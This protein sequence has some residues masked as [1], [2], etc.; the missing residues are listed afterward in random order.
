MGFIS[1]KVLEMPP[2]ATVSIADSVTEMRRQGVDDIDFSVG[3]A[4]ENTP[5]DICEAASQSMFDG[6]THQTMARESA[7]TGKPAPFC[8]YSVLLMERILI[9]GLSIWPSAG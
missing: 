1:K 7:N 3:R 8:D 2:S 4:V 6:D 5:A 9:L